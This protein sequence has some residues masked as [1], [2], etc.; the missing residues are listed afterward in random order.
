VIAPAGASCVYDIES[1]IDLAVLPFDAAMVSD[2]TS[3]SLSLER[4]HSVASDDAIILTLVETLWAVS[5]DGDRLLADHL[6]MA[7]L[8]RLASVAGP[9]RHAVPALSRRIVERI[10][11]LLSADLSAEIDLTTMAATAALSP[12]H[13]SRAFQAATGVPPY[14][15]LVQL[16]VERARALLEATDLPISEIA[17]QVGYD[18]PSYLARLFRREVGA[19]P[20]VYRREFRG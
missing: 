16:R 14:R 6:R 11:E 4:L 20:A 13:F 17:A 8:A 2:V 1:P 15:Y 9:P 19:A 12:F 5:P 7:V 3:R 18:D 10:V